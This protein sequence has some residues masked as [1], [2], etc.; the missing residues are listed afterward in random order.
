MHTYKVINKG[1]QE[2]HLRKMNETVTCTWLK[3]PSI[4]KLDPKI[5]TKHMNS[6]RP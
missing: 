2:S 3:I 1:A 4:G 6:L 5:L